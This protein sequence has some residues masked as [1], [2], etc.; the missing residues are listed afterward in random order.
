MKSAVLFAFCLAASVAPA[1]AQN[2]ADFEKAQAELARAV[3]LK[4]ADI[5]KRPTYA[6]RVEEAK[7]RFQTAQREWERFR[8]AECAARAAVAILISARTLEGLTIDCMH[9][10]TERRIMEISKY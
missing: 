5:A 2:R 7:S 4:L 10:L 9:S 3:E 1:A 8:D 6:D